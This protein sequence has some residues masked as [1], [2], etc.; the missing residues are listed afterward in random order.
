MWFWRVT[1]HDGDP[2]Q[3]EAEN[4]ES[5]IDKVR[6]TFG[7]KDIRSVI[8]LSESAT[9]RAIYGRRLSKVSDQLWGAYRETERLLAYVNEQFPDETREKVEDL[10][11]FLKTASSIVSD[12]HYDKPKN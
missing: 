5:A 9:K 8:C 2:I 7:A 4:A 11:R 6:E 12:I 1:P 3:V 10:L